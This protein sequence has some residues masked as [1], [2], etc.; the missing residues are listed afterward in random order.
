[1]LEVN[2]QLLPER[3]SVARRAILDRS[4]EILTKPPSEEHH[5]LNDALRSLRV[6]EKEG[7]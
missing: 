7:H 3:I 6:L 5:A 1:M 2:D 4:E